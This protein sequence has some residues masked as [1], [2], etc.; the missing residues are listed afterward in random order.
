MFAGKMGCFSKN[1][2][3]VKCD[4]IE[5]DAL[6]QGLIEGDVLK[7]NPLDIWAEDGDAER[8]VPRQKNLSF[9]AKK[10]L[11]FLQ[12]WK[13]FTKFVKENQIVQ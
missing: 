3:F 12:K 10:S 9:H 11:K 6:E 8:I 5:D 1:V 2:D 13:I 7:W 4:L